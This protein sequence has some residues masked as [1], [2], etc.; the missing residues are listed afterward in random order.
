MRIFESFKDAKLGQKFGKEN[1]STNPVV[2]NWYKSLN[3]LGHNGIDWGDLGRSGK[4]IY[5]DCDIEGDVTDIFITGTQGFGVYIN[6][7]DSDGQF[8]HVFWH[9]QPNIQAKLGKIQPGELIGYLDNSGQYTTGPH[10]HRG[11]YLLPRDMN[12]GYGGAIDI[13]PYYNPIFILVY[14]NM[15][16]QI[17]ILKRVVELLKQLIGIKK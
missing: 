7:T 5:W 15:T 13:Q 4:P 10:L 11:L 1:T 17:S 9:M 8:M 3:L 16:Q 12:N 14:L 6:T 2:V